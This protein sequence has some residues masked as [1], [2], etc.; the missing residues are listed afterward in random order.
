MA[1]YRTENVVRLTADGDTDTRAFVIDGIFVDGWMKTAY[2]DI[3]LLE[4]GS[5]GIL[6]KVG[7]TPDGWVMH[8][9]FPLWGLNVQ[10]DGIRFNIT[11]THWFW[12]NMFVYHR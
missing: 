1:V 4:Y 3:E 8:K 2:T 10:T 11:S 12:I 5:G 9:H 6:F 7:A